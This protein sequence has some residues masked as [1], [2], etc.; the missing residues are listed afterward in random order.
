MN[1]AD[2][3]KAGGSFWLFISEMQALEPDDPSYAEDFGVLV[4][5]LGDLED[6]I[7]VT[8]ADTFAGIAVKLRIALYHAVNELSAADAKEPEQ[9]PLYGAI[10]SA[11]DAAKRLAKGA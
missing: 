10:R 4:N 11:L 7:M 5:R 6:Q 8:P 1:D 2:L 3:N 9:H